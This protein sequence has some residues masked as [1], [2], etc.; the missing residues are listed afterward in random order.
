M[1]TKMILCA[2]LLLSVAA[3]Q[4]AVI[5]F[6]GVVDSS[7]K[8][9]VGTVVM[10]QFFF[11]PEN[12]EISR[13]AV[14]VGGDL[15][16]LKGDGARVYVDADP[17]HGSVY[18]QITD[19]SFVEFTLEAATPNGIIPPVDQFNLNDFTI[20]NDTFGHMTSLPEIDR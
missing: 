5:E 9:A 2:L 6:T 3:M 1:K 7:E 8:Y 17:S 4:A 14:M 11:N 18:Y 20:G 12:G 16:K 19:S 15:F 10:A 13:Y